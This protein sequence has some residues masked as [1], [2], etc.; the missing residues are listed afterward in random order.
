MRIMKPFATLTIALLAALACNAQISIDYC[1]SRARENYP[2]IKKYDI[3]GQT[4]AISLSDINKGWLPQIGLFAQTTVQSSVSAF[5]DALK[6]ML[7]KTGTSA[8]GMSKFQYKTGVELNQTIW[9]GGHSKAQRTI[10]RAMTAQNEAALEVEMYAIRERVEN[11]FFGILLIEEQMIKMQS[12]IDL[13]ESNHIRLSSMVANGIATKSDADM[14][15]AQILTMRQTLTEA[16]NTSDAYRRILS[17]YIDENLEDKPLVRPEADIPT[18]LDS[19]RPELSLFDRQ[20]A[21][22][23][24][25][26]KAIDVSTMPHIAFFAQAY[27]GYPGFNIFES[28]MKRDPSFN[29]MAGIKISW[30]INPFYSKQNSRSKLT[31]ATEMIRTDREIFLFN[32]NLLTTQEQNKIDGLKKIIKEDTRIVELRANVRRAAESQ[33][34]HGIID[35]TS[36]LTKINDETQAQLNQT[37]H[38]IQLLQ[39]IY[40]L[41]NTLNR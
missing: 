10:Q 22:N 23:A 31:L 29:A 5:P 15:E 30:N 25:H 28:V 37:L 35:A 24:E 18:D 21:L 16:Q 39:T 40:Q 20:I 9:D 2:L 33:L 41:K 7:D 17:I 34:T 32:Q 27:Y 38:E 1:L 11:I 36:L 19:N 3:V 4:E 6:T 14:I 26:L 13:L 8:A 12:T